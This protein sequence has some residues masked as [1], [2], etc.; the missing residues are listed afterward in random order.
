M[1]PREIKRGRPLL[2]ALLA[3]A[4]GCSEPPDS[5][6]ERIDGVSQS[7]VERF[8]ASEWFHVFWNDDGTIDEFDFLE[9]EI[10]DEDLAEVAR[11]PRLRIL[12]LGSTQI[13]DTGLAHL[14][15]LTELTM[16]G[17]RDT[18]VTGEGLR[19]LA[20]MPKLRSLLLARTKVT[21]DSLRHL[22]G[23][24]ALEELGLNGT[25]IT[26][27]G[28][29]HLHAVPVLARVHVADTRVTDAGVAALRQA[30]PGIQIFPMDGDP[31]FGEAI[32]D[33]RPQ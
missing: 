9:R 4:C 22:A 5:F 27:D 19:Y 24:P 14:A 30:R 28:L 29:R 15:T 26:D 21:D 17:L 32:E 33:A 13:S 18:R 23:L 6:V 2:G 11:H 16:L 12:K 31:V 10:R 20:G 7:F 8:I 25:P 1:P 3:A